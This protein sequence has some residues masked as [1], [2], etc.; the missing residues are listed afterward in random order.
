LQLDGQLKNKETER[1]TVQSELDDLLMVY[2]DLEEK[3]KEYKVG[4]VLENAACFT[5]FFF[6]RPVQQDRLRSLGET[7]SDADD[8]DEGADE[9]GDGDDGSE[10]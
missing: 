7:V 6:S 10:T 2:S 8:D 4:F 1:Q 5:A 9:D 3:S